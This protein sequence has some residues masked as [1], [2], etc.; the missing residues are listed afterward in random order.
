M[1][2]KLYH[3]KTVWQTRN[4][5]QMFVKNSTLFTS[6]H[7]QLLAYH[8]VSADVAVTLIL[9][10]HFFS[11]HNETNKQAVLWC[12]CH[13]NRIHIFLHK[14]PKHIAPDLHEY[15]FSTRKN[16]SHLN[17]SD[18]KYEPLQAS[19]RGEVTHTI[20]AAFEE[21]LPFKMHMKMK[22]TG[23][24]FIWWSPKSLRLYWTDADHRTFSFTLCFLLQLLVILAQ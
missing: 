24:P 22:D 23:K 4:K 8:A 12:I 13:L 3:R 1:T 15:D 18:R 20:K 17:L 11:Q 16:K 2:L 9:P 14:T 5:K 19:K 21:I 7:H 6:Q 10:V